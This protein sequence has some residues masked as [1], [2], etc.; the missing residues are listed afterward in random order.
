MSPL[1]CFKV[2]AQGLVVTAKNV[3]AVVSDMTVKLAN[4]E[5]TLATNFNA[6]LKTNTC[7]FASVSSVQYKLYCCEIFFIK[8]TVFLGVLEEIQTANFY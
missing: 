3:E 5:M 2:L 7:T 8:K 1:F 4:F 6:F